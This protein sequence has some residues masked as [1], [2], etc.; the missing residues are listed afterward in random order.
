MSR[1]DRRNN[2]PVVIQK[3]EQF[4][5][6]LPGLGGSSNGNGGGWGQGT[7]GAKPATGQSPS[8]NPF[9]IPKAA[10]LNVFSQTYP[11]NYFVEW[12]L[13]TWRYACDQAMK[14]GYTLSYATLVS[15]A[16]ECSPFI[17]SL[18]EALG[19]ALER[20][21]VFIVDKKGDKL[22]DWTKELCDSTWTIQLRKEI[23]FSYF[24]GFS[25]INFD[26]INKKVY[27]YPMQDID[28][29]NRMLRSSTFSF[30]D[31]ML[32]E[33]HDNLLF[34]QPSSSY[35]AFLGWMQPITRSFIQMNVNKNN[36][37]AA[38]KR[39]AFP[40]LTVGYPQADGAVNPVTGESMNPYKIQAEQIAANIDPSQAL[41]YPYTKDVTGN[42]QKAIEIGFEQ[43]KAGTSA[44]KIYQEFN[45][46]EK[47]EILQ[48]CLGG[49]LTAD[50]GKSGSRA[51]G[52]VMERK[53]DSVVESKMAFVLSVLNGDF[54]E[55]SKKFYS[56]FPEG[57]QY[58]YD[59]T[60]VLGMQ[61]IILLAQ[62]LQLS[63]KRLTDD[64]YEA[65]GIA[66]EFI[67]EAPQNEIEPPEPKAT[68]HE[69]AI[70][71]K[72]FFSAKKKS[73]WN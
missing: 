69:M 55:K 28:P 67:E 2:D 18:F 19:S 5:A 52:E 53:F 46:D 16:Y 23:L 36:W 17:R 32:F 70:P 65:N 1:R 27:K 30:G 63:G 64:F 44:H 43:P 39:L 54:L 49:T 3:R 10:G 31:G 15:W 35:E 20:I 41:T 12:N 22:D 11:S 37:I 68:I 71:R 4:G 7:P 26:P 25:G 33:D 6:I 48:M 34:I 40:V 59:S 73:D 56:N 45:A 60:K 38:G 51:L 58:S 42:I 14:M 47:N 50:V 66:R 9:V 57:A 13:S 29:I 62:S 72:T 21:P 61:E 24:W 8:V